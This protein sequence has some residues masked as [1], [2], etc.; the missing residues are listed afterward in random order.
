MAASADSFERA[1]WWRT[2]RE[3]APDA[4][5]LRGAAEADIAIIG[6]GF[7]GLST[8]LFLAEA[9]CKPVLLEARHIGFGAS[10]RNGGQV[11]PG[12]K[13]DPETLLA[14]YG[15]E[16]GAGLIEFA[17]GAADLVFDTIAR[18]QI[19]CAPAR[20]GW[21]QAAHSERALGPVL[22][23]AGQWRDRGVPVEILDREAL[24]RRTGVSVYHGG[25]RDP[26]AGAVQPLDYARGLARAARAAGATIHEGAPVSGLTRKG[27]DWEL[28]TPKGRL[29]ARRVVLA[30]NAH[31]GDLMPGL[32]RSILPV[33]SMI[34]ATK[35]LPEDLRVR[36]MPGGV[37]LSETRKLAFYMRQS[38]DGRIVFGGR[39]SVGATESPR[40]MTELKAG[41]LRLFPDLEG[42]GADHQW[43]GQLALS[44]DGLPHLH[45]PEPGLH[46]ALAYNG[47][48]IAMATAFGRMIAAW[49][50]EGREPVFPI[51]PIS[52]IAWHGVREP[53]MNLGIRW[54]WLKDRMGFAS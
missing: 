29:T 10:G 49:I 34:V 27:S 14:K 11:I 48:G 2:S 15:T 46:I 35:P 12:L 9:G 7:T 16:R 26:R 44:M 8:A 42:V 13:Y 5:P 30:T 4:A 38:A 22:A 36:L 41:L 45:Q 25:W 32:A 51:T 6:G 43:S 23:R 1:L 50:A 20:A 53:V 39:G 28:T 40:L 37:V 54:Y 33:Q 21:I 47:R 31:S 19:D 3:P 52:P 17:G 18:H 24:A